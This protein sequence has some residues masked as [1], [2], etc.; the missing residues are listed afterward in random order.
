MNIDLLKKIAIVTGGAG[1][2]GR[3]MVR[4]LA[5]CGAD[6]VIHYRSSGAKP[7]S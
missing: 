3:V 5:K 2:L 7:R 4:I 1:E 6:V